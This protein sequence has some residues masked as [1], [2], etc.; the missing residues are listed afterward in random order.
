MKEGVMLGEYVERRIKDIFRDVAQMD[1]DLTE[2]EAAGLPM[3]LFQAESKLLT[4]WREF[5]TGA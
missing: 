5:I 2:D 4:T 1:N 3:T